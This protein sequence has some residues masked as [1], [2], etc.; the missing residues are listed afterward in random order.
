MVIGILSRAAIGTMVMH[1]GRH[2]S[3]AAVVTVPI[4]TV[5][6]DDAR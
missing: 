2:W 5:E 6:G 4:H 3:K 1:F